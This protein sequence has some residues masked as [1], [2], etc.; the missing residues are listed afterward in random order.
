MA[1]T[2]LLTADLTTRRILG[3]FIQASIAWI[4]LTGITL[5]SNFIQV[6]Y[7]FSSTGTN[8]L[9]ML[10]VTV[11]CILDLRGTFSGSNQAVKWV[12]LVTLPL[13][14]FLMTESFVAMGSGI[15]VKSTLT[16]LMN[17]MGF[18]MMLVTA[19]Y[20]AGG[21][22]NPYRGLLFLLKP[23]FAVVGYIVITG[24]LASVLVSSG[25]VEPSA[26][27]LPP[28]ITPAGKNVSM[29]FY[30]SQITLEYDEAFQLFGFRLIRV[31][32]L[33]KE[34]SHAALLIAPALFLLGV[35][36]MKR[37]WRKRAVIGAVVLFLLL[38]ASVASWIVL[39]LL[40]PLVAWRYRSRALAVLFVCLVIVASFLLLKP[41][42][43]YFDVEQFETNIVSHKLFYIGN[44]GALTGRYA[45]YLSSDKLIGVGLF[46]TVD[47]G[48]THPLAVRGLL[49][50]GAEHLLY[51]LLGL[52][53]LGLILSSKER[54][55]FGFALLYYILHMQ[56]DP[57][58]MLEF[59]IF[60]FFIVLA[61][62][63]LLR[64]PS[65][66]ATSLT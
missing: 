41:V 66:H 3:F 32:G 5:V 16:T 12:M 57:P 25:M 8:F 19:F 48:P 63:A 9:I 40:L 26:W 43:E 64:S 37:R 38:T 20:W 30:L 45:D 33:S 56:K 58:H 53:A 54:A 50:I 59:P 55:C 24:I 47:L 14:G 23:F 39:F 34:P 29:P 52:I 18:I 13:V 51:A 46:G 49:S 7:A 1:Q 28:E 15:G 17:S 2:R 10:A 21:G 22:V 60:T 4:L 35:L 6:I 44:R 27:H 31:A 65:S 11:F 62:I 42:R 61:G 36:A